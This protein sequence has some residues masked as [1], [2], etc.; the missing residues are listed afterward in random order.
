MGGSGGLKLL[1]DTHIWLW[2]L[3][4][5]AK[6]GKRVMHELRDP[7]NET[8][9]SPISTWEALTLNAKGRIQLPAELGE[10]VRRATSPLREAP[11]THEIALLSRQLVLPHNDPADH[12]LAATAQLLKLTL[13]TA[14][15]NLLGLGNIS[16]LANR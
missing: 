2:S 10:W 9:L 4:D 13:V 8:W 1:L 12:L 16:T 5:P 6:L 7:Q 14:D 15:G 11:L 3:N